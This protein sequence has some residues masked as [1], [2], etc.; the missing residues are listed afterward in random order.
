MLGIVSYALPG[1]VGVDQLEGLQ[2]GL[3]LHHP[4]TADIHKVSNNNK[5]CTQ[6]GMVL[7]EREFT[8][9]LIMTKCVNVLRA[10]QSKANNGPITGSDHIILRLSLV[11]A[12]I[13]FASLVTFDVLC[14][15]YLHTAL[16]MR[17]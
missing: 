14:H 15:N 11:H 1:G 17:T 8:M 4:A 6:G 13:Y 16:D 7:E 3:L 5:K 9:W 2:R 12:L 10:K